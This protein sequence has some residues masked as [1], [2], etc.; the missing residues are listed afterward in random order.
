MRPINWTEGDV[1]GIEL[2]LSGCNPTVRIDW[3]DGSVK[4]YYGNTI[5]ERHIYIQKM[6]HSRL[7]S[8]RQLFQVQSIMLT[9]QEE[10]AIMRSS[11]SARRRRLG[12]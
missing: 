2:R 7:S 4:T 1:Y 12:R 11:I 8:Q 10:T 5:L 9:P 3:G 6:N